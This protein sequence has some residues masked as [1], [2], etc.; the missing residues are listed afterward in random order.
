MTESINETVH[1]CPECDAASMQ[2]N[3]Q[4]PRGNQN[5]TKWRCGDCGFKTDEPVIRKKRGTHGNTVSGLAKKLLDADPD[6]WP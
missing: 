4:T 3:T 1:V 6:E 2:R 5:T